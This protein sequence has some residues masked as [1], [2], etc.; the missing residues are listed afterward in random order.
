MRGW[1]KKEFKK[2]VKE[3]RPLISES[4]EKELNEAETRRRLEKVLTELLGYDAFSDL[5]G[6]LMVRGTGTDHLDYAVKLN[7]QLR[8]II[9]VKPACTT[10][11][12][13]HLRQVIS[14]GMNAGVEWCLL[15]NS[16]DWKLYHIEFTKPIK[17]TLV[18]DF[19]I[20]NDCIDELYV[21]MAHLTKRSI[22][23][24]S[25]EKLWQKT[26]GLSPMQLFKATFTSSTINSVRKNIRKETEIL[27]TPEEVVSAFRKMLNENALK[28]LNDMSFSYLERKPRK[29]RAKKE[30]QTEILNQG[31]NNVLSDSN[32][33]TAN[34]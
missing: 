3:L 11:G 24:N 13:K 26:E 7:G 4:R 19:N 8:I 15:T 10:L 18:L 2:R 27:V 28:I 5:S 21:K 17:P 34:S 9:E 20:L 33:G 22:L 12:E 14:Y 29:I 31:T 25:L 23:K 6:E 1:D 32:S 16:V 30:E